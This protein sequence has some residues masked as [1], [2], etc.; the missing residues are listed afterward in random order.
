MGRKALVVFCFLFLIFVWGEKEEM[1]VFLRKA[2]WGR[3]RVEMERKK[4][5]SVGKIKLELA[6]GSLLH[7]AKVV[8]RTAGK[9]ETSKPEAVESMGKVYEIRADSLLDQKAEV[10]FE[11]KEKNEVLLFSQDGKNWQ[12]RDP[13]RGFNKTYDLGEFGFLTLAT[14]K[15]LDEEVVK[16]DIVVEG[17]IRYRWRPKFDWPD[18]Q[19]RD[20]GE[21]IKIGLFL[22][23]AEGIWGEEI[24]GEI[25]QGGKYQLVIPKGRVVGIAGKKKLEFKIRVYA[26][27]K[28]VCGV[29]EEGEKRMGVYEETELVK[30]E[31]GQE[32]I[33][34]NLDIGDELSAAFG[35]VDLVSEANRMVKENTSVLL[36][37]VEVVMGDF[38]SFFG[39]EEKVGLDEVAGVILIDRTPPTEW[40]EFEILSSYGEFVMYGLR[41]RKMV[42]V[43]LGKDWNLREKMRKESAYGKGWALFFAGLAMGMPEYKVYRDG[44]GEKPV[45]KMNLEYDSENRYGSEFAGAV[46]ETFWDLTD[47]DGRLIDTDKDGGRVPLKSIF[48]SLGANIL[49]KFPF[50]HRPETMEDYYDSLVKHELGE[51]TREDVCRIFRR[52]GMAVGECNFKVMDRQGEGKNHETGETVGERKIKEEEGDQGKIQKK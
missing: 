48:E 42:S 50:Y 39:E 51:A 1:T 4:T 6:E 27:K 32:K 15:K 14:F 33:V 44:V 9:K 40:D 46:A 21:G 41:G 34:L 29:S 2:F 36:G 26:Q 24:E 7:E 8:F 18:R 37:P 19:L 43:G 52:N 13:M 31:E 12:W 11:E 16:E 20:A 25:G 45:F 38:N 47:S 28:D 10:T 49:G 30:P 22:K 17:R 3:G 23:L 35:V 5:F